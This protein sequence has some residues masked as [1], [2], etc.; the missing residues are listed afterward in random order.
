M[1]YTRGDIIEFYLDLPYQESSKPHPF[2]IISNEEVFEQDGMYICA[3]LTHSKQIDQFSFE[4]EPEMFNKNSDGK[5]SQVRCHLIVSIKEEDINV[6]GARNSL[7]NRYVDRLV[8]R[9]EVVSLS[10]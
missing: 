5:F 8:S 9:I 3:M 10:I 4:I 6:T 7:K 2:V 1:A